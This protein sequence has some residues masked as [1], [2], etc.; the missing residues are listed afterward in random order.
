MG[1]EGR[2]GLGLSFKG[3]WFCWAFAG[4]FWDFLPCK[5]S[6]FA[7]RVPGFLWG[8]FWEGFGVAEG[9]GLCFALSSRFREVSGMRCSRDVSAVVAKRYLSRASPQRFWRSV[10]APAERLPSVLVDSSQ[11]E[12]RVSYSVCTS[13]DRFSGSAFTQPRN[14]EHFS[15]AGFLQHLPSPALI[16]KSGIRRFC[17][18]N[19]DTS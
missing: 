10:Q 12:A 9:F 16:R 4:N 15:F 19:S 5:V 13:F 2:A 18:E 8:G 17:S 3:F 6:G 7:G 14:I 11:A 1:F